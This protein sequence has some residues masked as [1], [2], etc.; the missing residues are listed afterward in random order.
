M[1]PIIYKSTDTGAPVLAGN[2][3]T[4]LVN[5]LNKCLVTGYGDKPAAGWTMPFV[6]AEGTIAAFRN[7]TAT[8]TGFFFKADQTISPTYPYEFKLSAFEAMSSET[9]GAFPFGETPSGTYLSST[10]NTTARPWMVVAN[11]NWMF[12][13]IMRS[14]TTFPTA[15]TMASSPSSFNGPFFFFGDIDKINA[16]DGFACMCAVANSSAGFGNSSTVGLIN[17]NHNMARRLSGVSGAITPGVSLAPPQ[18]AGLFQNS[19]N[20]YSNTSGLICSKLYVSDI[21]SA[22]LVVHR[23]HLNRVLV[24]HQKAPFEPLEQVVIDGKTYTFVI[25]CSSSSYVFSLFIDM[26]P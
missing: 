25:V 20:P 18:K 16:S 11:E 6:N 4:C 23:G 19:G 1:V 26:T 24:P 7:S 5:L 2:D 9:T 10:N 3:R 21:E 17:T 15:A 13:Y 12:L 14:T 8:G 22:S